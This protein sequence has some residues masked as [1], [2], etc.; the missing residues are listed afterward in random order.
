[1][2]MN[3]WT[4]IASD[5]ERFYDDWDA[6]VVL[7]GTDT[8]AYTS[9]ALSYMLQDL[10]K[11][12]VVTG[13]QVPMI[14]QRNDGQANFQGALLVAG[15]Y[16]VPEVTLFFHNKLY[17]GNRTTKAHATRYT[18]PAIIPPLHQQFHCLLATG[19]HRAPPLALALAFLSLSPYARTQLKQK[20]RC[21]SMLGI[22][23]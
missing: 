22:Y 16:T 5:I 8:M 17:R 15:H 2:D 11:T 3:D 9:S 12:V 13:A 7:H 23:Y 18:I 19:I 1:M 10:G 21:C 6:F 4:H 14:E 20:R